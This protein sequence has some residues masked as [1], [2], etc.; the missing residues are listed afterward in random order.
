VEY[1][2]RCIK[3]DQILGS[4]TEGIDIWKQS[5]IDFM[6][7]KPTLRKNR[8]GVVVFC[9]SCNLEVD[10]TENSNRIGQLKLF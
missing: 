9:P 8:D 2:S 5:R 10:I 6:P 1:Q 7:L 4:V 3:C